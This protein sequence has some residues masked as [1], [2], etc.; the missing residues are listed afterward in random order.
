MSGPRHLLDPSRLK[1]S[2]ARKGL[3]LDQLAAVS[4]VSR[5]MISKIERGEGSPTATTLARLAS[6]LDVTMAS[7]FS[8]PASQPETL[9]RRDSQTEW[10]DPASGYVR[11]NVAP[12]GA[13]VEIVEVTFPPAARVLFDNLVPTSGIEQLI[14]LIE[15][16]MALTIGDEVHVLEPGD[17]LRMR[18]DR[19][20][21]FHNP[22][23]RP[24]RYAVVLARAGHQGEP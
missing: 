3:T 20:I 16:R 8:A 1:A 15:G 21:T 11:R 14:W 5:A 12:A 17:C 13:A 18:L 19:P 7:L 24:A 2:R 4:G 22:D 9:R 10:A 6:A 23:T